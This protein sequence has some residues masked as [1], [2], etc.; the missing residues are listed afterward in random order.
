MKRVPDNLPWSNVSTFEVFYKLH[1]EKM[2][3]LCSKLV[4]DRDTCCQV[5]Q[6]AFF[7]LWEK[8][9]T[10][11]HVDNP[12]AYLYQTVRYTALDYGRK[13]KKEE[14]VLEAYAKYQSPETDNNA[15]ELIAQIKKAALQLPGKCKAIFEMSF[16]EGFSNEEISAYLNISPLTVKKQKSI[17]LQKIRELVPVAVSAVMLELL[18]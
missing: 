7:K 9:F 10:L 12:A 13:R 2:V 8:R 17:A 16:F 4:D 15:E 6:D 18:R 11:D 1:F 5:V 3:V 14:E